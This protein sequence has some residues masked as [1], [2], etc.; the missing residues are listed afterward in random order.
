MKFK[1]GDRVRFIYTNSFI[2]F[3]SIGIIISIKN[4]TNIKNFYL[5]LL[6]WDDDIESC[7][8]RLKDLEKINRTHKTYLQYMKDIVK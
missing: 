2:P 8:C 1:K 5:Y 3:H 4:T 7:W 6:Q